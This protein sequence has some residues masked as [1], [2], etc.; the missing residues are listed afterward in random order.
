[1]IEIK[2]PKDIPSDS[3][4][5]PSDPDATYSGY[6]G[7]GYPAVIAKWQVVCDF[8]DMLY[9]FSIK[10][11]ANILSCNFHCSGQ[12]LVLYYRENIRFY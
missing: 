7:Q 9:L 8:I 10:I 5:N 4:E 12:I 6:K 2:K 3:L 11:G 1:Q